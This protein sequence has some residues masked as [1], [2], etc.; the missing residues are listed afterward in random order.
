MFAL[1]VLFPAFVILGSLPGRFP[2][3]PMSDRLGF[4]AALTLLLFAGWPAVMVWRN[5]VRFSSAF[6]MQRPSAWFLLVAV[7]W[8]GALWLWAYELEILTLSSNRLD[9]LRDVFEQIK[10]DLN[11]VPLAW[12]LAT[13][14]IVPA[15]C[16]EWF[17]RGYL[18]S[19]FRA[20]MTALQAVLAS[21]ALFG[22]FH[23]VVRDILF[24]ERFLPSGMMGLMLGWLAVRSGSVWPGMLL[25]VMHNG[26]LL[27]IEAHQEQL[28]AWG[29]GLQAHQHL[30]W[31]W[32]TVSGLAI[33]AGAC[34]L[35]KTSPSEPVSIP[36]GP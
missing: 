30:P 16:E 18:L 13:L 4:S 29:I 25:H 19:G 31:P 1:A 12:K 3:L 22:L 28:I 8:G 33:L 26:L 17:F 23:V 6:R 15:A 35:I 32:L 34:V 14:A 36:R 10:L 20:R 7:L 9:V 24:F 21:A 5:S 27:S 11:K 2:F